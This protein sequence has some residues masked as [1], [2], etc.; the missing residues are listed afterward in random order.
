MKVVVFCDILSSEATLFVYYIIQM[1]FICYCVKTNVTDAQNFRSTRP[2]CSSSVYLFVMIWPYY[3]V[4]FQSPMCKPNI[5]S[6][7]KGSRNIFRHTFYKPLL[8][9]IKLD[10]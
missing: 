8:F 5:M 1:P 6:Q 2:I 4:S 7:R 9:L 3:L 10:T